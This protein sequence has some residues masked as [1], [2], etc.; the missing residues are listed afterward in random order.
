[1]ADLPVPQFILA[2]LDLSIPTPLQKTVIPFDDGANSFQKSYLMLTGNS[3]W[4][5]S[6]ADRM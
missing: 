3:R 1:M 5:G 2:R 6:V 4:N